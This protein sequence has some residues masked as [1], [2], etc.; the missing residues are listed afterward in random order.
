MAPSG[1]DEPGGRTDGGSGAKA[2]RDANGGTVGDSDGDSDGA[3]RGARAPDLPTDH[4]AARTA[5]AHTET[6]S[7]SSSSSTATAPGSASPSDDDGLV[8]RAPR[9]PITPS[10]ATRAAAIP[11]SAQTDASDSPR[12]ASANDAALKL[13]AALAANFGEQV[14]RALEWRLDGSIESLAFVDHHLTQARDETRE[15]ILA[16]LA[17]G[18]G[19]YFGE[20]VRDHVGGTWIGDGEDPRR[21]RLLL[22]PQF[23]HFSPVDLAFEAITGEALTPGDARLPEGPPFDAEYHLGPRS[24]SAT[25]DDGK[26]ETPGNGGGQ[27]REDDASWLRERLAELPPVPQAEFHSLTCRFETLQLMLEMLATKHEAEGRPPRTLGLSDYVQIL[28]ARQ[29]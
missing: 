29:V 3:T 4:T 11:P 26:G 24:P 14:Q 2:G 25:Q 10:S 27:P 7:A 21:L 22:A 19:A 6:A 16:L 18:A 8:G 13:V 15:P 28:A 23:I 1:T 12:L 9:R 20:L 5:D 17:A